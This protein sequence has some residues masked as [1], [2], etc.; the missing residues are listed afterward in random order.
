MRVSEL[1]LHPVRLSTGGGHSP[2]PHHHNH[3]HLGCAMCIL[4]C[5]PS[6]FI[7]SRREHVSPRYPSYATIQSSAY[8]CWLRFRLIKILQGKSSKDV[9]AGKRGF[10]RGYLDISEK[11]QFTH[12]KVQL[13][14]MRKKSKS[15]ILLLNICD[16]SAIRKNI[17]V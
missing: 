6:G 8:T 7:K 3:H 14:H 9:S 4:G 11:E 10:G 16:N 1:L 13:Y 12:S 15:S 2:V 5:T 17:C